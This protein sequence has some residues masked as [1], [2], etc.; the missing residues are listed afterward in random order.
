M[1]RVIV[2]CKVKE[3]QAAQNVA[4]IQSVFAALNSSRPDGLRYTSLTVLRS[5][6]LHLL[7]Q[8]MDQI[9]S[10]LSRSSK[11]SLKTLRHVAK[12]LPSPWQLTRWGLIESLMNSS[13]MRTISLYSINR[14]IWLALISLSLAACVTP[15]LKTQG[16][17]ER[18]A[19]SI[20]VEVEAIRFMNY[21]YFEEIPEPEYSDTHL[22]GRRGIV[23]IT[24]DAFYLMDGNLNTG[25]KDYFY[26]VP[27]SDITGASNLDEQIQIKNRETLIALYV[28][29]WNGLIPDADRTQELYQSL[30]F[31]D[32]QGFEAED[33]YTLNHIRPSDEY[34]P[35][36]T[37]HSKQENESFQKSI[38]DPNMETFPF[39]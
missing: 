35:A 22:A 29:D 30:V 27:F 15:P 13:R 32:V 3:D 38:T 11:R 20:G 5:S 6:I 34:T 39:R 31:A 16:H 12:N 26:N 9:P 36:S 1:K 2:R 28:Y 8:Q 37:M 21:Y 14:Y 10:P 4:Y 33:T 23:A 19:E 17:K 24:D 7:K 18:L 25:P